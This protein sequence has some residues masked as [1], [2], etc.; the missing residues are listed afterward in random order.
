[1]VE[2]PSDAPASNQIEVS[3]FGPGV[4]E[5]VLLHLGDGQWVIIDSCIDAKT[6]VV[7]LLYLERIGVDPATAVS[8]VVATHAHDDHIA[9]IADV[10]KAC[11]SARFV[12]ADAFTLEEIVTHAVA[13]ELKPVGRPKIYSEYLSIFREAG[14]RG[15]PDGLS[16]LN[17][18][19]E[20]RD[21][22]PRD[23]TRFDRPLVL[24][25][26][27]PSD[28]A[29]RRSRA[30]ISTQVPREGESI[31]TPMLD[32]NLI[33]IALWVEVG[34]KAML[35]GGDLR[36]GP[37]GC[38][39]SAVL[40]THH[41]TMRAS[42]FKVPHHGSPNADLPEVWLKLLSR[43]PLA[44]IAPYR[45]GRTPRP[46]PTDVARIKGYTD[47]AFVAADTR[48][49]PP[50]KTIEDAVATLQS[51]AIAARQPRG[52]VGHVRARSFAGTDTWAIDLQ[53][54]AQAL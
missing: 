9:G 10:F 13:D 43:N 35:L 49:P 45:A 28:E 2:S 23:S 41:P 51:L 17:F 37:A 52:S 16:A 42:L 53:E 3:I 27:A 26:L 34:G 47:R 29:K 39:W 19:S 33:S 14:R 40:L 18:V 5:S 24:R 30:F 48:V 15:L 25:A 4:G 12:L 8:H 7:P 6:G 44:L 32:P 11:K 31:R 22:L 21:L 1:M 36:S 50:T 54:P 46:S 38:G 20:G